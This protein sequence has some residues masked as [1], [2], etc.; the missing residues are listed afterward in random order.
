MRGKILIVDDEPSVLFLVQ[1]H[2]EN[3]GFNV[4]SAECGAEAISTLETACFDLAVIDLG[5]P[6]MSG[7][8]LLAW[9]RRNTPD[10]VPIVLSGTSSVSDAIRAVQEGAFDFLRKPIEDL[11]V[12]LQHVERA[13]GHKRLRERNTELLK[14]REAKNIELE[15]RLNQLELAHST[16]KSQSLA[17]H[18]DLHRAMRIQY[19]LLPNVIPFSDRISASVIYHPAT[20]VGGDLYDIFQVDDKHV[21]MYVA[22]AAG[23]GVSAAMLAL[24]LKLA[25]KPIEDMGKEYRVVGPDTVLRALNHIISE[26]TFGHEMFAS[27]TYLLL[28]TETRQVRFSS[29][30]HPAILVRRADGSVEPFRAP[31]PALGLNPNVCYPDGSFTMSDGD[32]I[33]L[34]TDGVLDT[35]DSEGGFYGTE[36]L[37]DTISKANGSVDRITAAIENDLEEFRAHAMYGDDITVVALGV[38]AQ[39]APYRPPQMPADPVSEEGRG[40]TSAEVRTATEKGRVF[41]TLNGAG[42][43]RESQRLLAI[44]EEARRAGES[45]II[46]DFGGCP[47]LDSTFFGVLHNLATTTEQNG[48]TRFELQNVTPPVLREMSELGLT[49][50]MMHFR[51]TPIPLPRAMRCVEGSAPGDIEMGRLLLWAHEALVEADPSN[52]DRFA[53]VLQVLHAQAKGEPKDKSD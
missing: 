47:H 50:V 42:S 1:H 16:L 41:I 40:I 36:R 25:V 51:S 17:L 29:A 31:S 23:H 12:L 28:N 19:A 6:D 22:D 43:W 18:V 52:A 20:R 44:V 32:V 5:L 46:L 21:G 30:G 33:V 35:R 38:D 10:V 9:M 14:E 15:N 4:C 48:G 24:F 26:E 8:D 7:L 53:A 39:A 2:L 13:V 11:V 45:S 37:R 34:Y 49:S 3:A 27:M